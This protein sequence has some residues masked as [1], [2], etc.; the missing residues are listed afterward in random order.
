MRKTLHSRSSEDV[1][2]RLDRLPFWFAFLPFFILGGGVGAI[3]FLTNSVEGMAP[4]ITLLPTFALAIVLA[5]TARPFGVVLK[6]DLDAGT[7]LG[8]AKRKDGPTPR[9]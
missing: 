8:T 3:C 5:W 4:V 2:R 7:G 9:R 6:K 1:R